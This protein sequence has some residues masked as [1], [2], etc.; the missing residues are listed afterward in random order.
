MGQ[1]LPY[2]V[3]II[4][5]LTAAACSPGQIET[6]TTSPPVPSSPPTLTSTTL[7]APSPQQT[8]ASSPTATSTTTPTPTAPP[9]ATSTPG[10][11]LSNQEGRLYVLHDEVLFHP[12]PGSE[13]LDQ[14][15]A[16]VYPGLASFRQSLAWYDEPVSTGQIIEDASFEETF[17][18][19]S[20]VTLVT[21]G[22]E[23]D[24]QLPP[25]GDLYYRARTTGDRL[26][27]LWYEYSLPD[28]QA[29]RE[30]YAQVANGATY[31]LYKYYDGNQAVLR[32]WCL[33]YT[34]LFEKS[35]KIR[36]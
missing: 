2:L 1:K 16:G 13:V 14:A 4:L 9:T 18:L 3:L 10:C 28:H 21:V 24:W 19:N 23:I 7:P 34:A 5:P 11:V 32:E 30:Q 22:L 17:Q 27:T 8:A 20:A 29:V 12:G 33:A 36:P 26:V 31:A 35:P 15:L 6:L 25:Y